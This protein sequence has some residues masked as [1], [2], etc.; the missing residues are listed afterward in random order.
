VATDEEGEG[1]LVAPQHALQ[2][3]RIVIAHDG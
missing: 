2:N 3:Y 1:V